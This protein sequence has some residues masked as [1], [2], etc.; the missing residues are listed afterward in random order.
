MV[1]VIRHLIL[2]DQDIFEQL[3]SYNKE[4]GEV[5]ISVLFYGNRESMKIFLNPNSVCVIIENAFDIGVCSL[6]YKTHGKSNEN[7]CQIKIV[8]ED[9][10]SISMA[11][12]KEEIGS[13]VQ[14]L[15]QCKR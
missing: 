13:R 14:L 2:E 6:F 9:V 7:K 1:E 15:Q 3:D 10:N 11:S 5:S 4:T 12:S 8:P